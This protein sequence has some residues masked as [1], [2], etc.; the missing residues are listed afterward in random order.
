[1]TERKTSSK[2]V[3]AETAATVQGDERIDKILSALEY[4]AD[5]IQRS[6]D[7]DPATA[8]ERAIRIVDKSIHRQTGKNTWSVRV[9]G[10]K[11]PVVFKSDADTPAEATREF[12]QRFGTRFRKNAQKD[13]EN[14]S[15]EKVTS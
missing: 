7:T 10:F 11:N 4:Q 9:P 8:Y 3:Q 1:M 2:E 6:K 12:E 5:L 15:I 13:S 14:H